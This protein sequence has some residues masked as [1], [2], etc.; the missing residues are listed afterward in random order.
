MYRQNQRVNSIARDMV[1]GWFPEP[2]L[3]RAG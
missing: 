1:H 2:S 3:R